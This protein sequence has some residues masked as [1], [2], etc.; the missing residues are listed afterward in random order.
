MTTPTLVFS[1]LSHALLDA[2]T[3][4]WTTLPNNPLQGLQHVEVFRH[5]EGL[6]MKLNQGERGFTFCR[7]HLGFENDAETFRAF[8]RNPVASQYIPITYELAGDGTEVVSEILATYAKAH[9]SPLADKIDWLVYT[10]STSS[11]GRLLILLLP[12]EIVERLMADHGGRLTTMFRG[13]LS[14]L[15]KIRSLRPVLGLEGDDDQDGD[16]GDVGIV[17]RALVTEYG[18]GGYRACQAIHQSVVREVCAHPNSGIAIGP[19][20]VWSA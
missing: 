2:L 4:E 18:Q 12:R 7:R 20:G 19:I 10:P 9:G 15:R 13:P 14:G 5:P 16:K 1:G 3:L 8:L 11:K 17:H 6:I